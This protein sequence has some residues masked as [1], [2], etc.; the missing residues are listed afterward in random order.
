M[1][2]LF[3]VLA[4]LSLALYFLGPWVVALILVPAFIF[5]KLFMRWMGVALAVLALGAPAI[6]KADKVDDCME[7]GECDLADRAAP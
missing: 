6:S 2:Y 1:T 5:A 4:I 7:Y 3:A